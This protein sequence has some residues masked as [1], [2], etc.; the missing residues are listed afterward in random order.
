M[1]GLF[2]PRDKNNFLVFG[3]PYLGELEALNVSKVIQSNWL[4]TGPMVK[5]FESKFS[6]LKDVNDRS[7]S[8]NL[9][10]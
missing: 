9:N 6:I 5:E 7:G 2:K 3:Q 4:G 1:H 8:G 10:N